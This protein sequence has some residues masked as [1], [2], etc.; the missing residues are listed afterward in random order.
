MLLTIFIFLISIPV[1]YVISMLVKEIITYKKLNFYKRQGL[2]VTYR[3]LIGNGEN[4]IPK[5]L[6]NGEVDS[7]DLNV[8]KTNISNAAQNG[9]QAIIWNNS[10]SMNCAIYPIGKNLLKELLVKEFDILKKISKTPLISLGFFVKSGKE[11]LRKR[12]VFSQ[13]FHQDNLRLMAPK[14]DRIIEK[15][16]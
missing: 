13:F 14:I 7:D 3:A 2:K 15:G 4:Y 1:L 6:S 16:F 10:S 11:A 12:K 9:D 8:L 5:K